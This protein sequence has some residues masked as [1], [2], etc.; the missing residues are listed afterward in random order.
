MARGRVIDLSLASFFPRPLAT[1]ILSVFLLISLLGSLNFYV[2]YI[3][4]IFIRIFDT[5]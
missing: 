4:S 3:V 5:M 1:N 2:P